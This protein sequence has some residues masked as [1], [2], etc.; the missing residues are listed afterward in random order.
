MKLTPFFVLS[1]LALLV[2]CNRQNTLRE[3]NIPTNASLSVNSV[4]DTV[5]EL[6]NNIMSVYQDKK[7]NYWFGSWQ[8]GLYKYD[9]KTILHFTT[10]NGLPHNRVEDIQED[11]RGNLYFNT[12]GGVCKLSGQKI[13]IL[14]P[15]ISDEWNLQ[16]GD[17]W[18][19]SLQFT[20]KVYR[21]NGKVLY[22]LQFPTCKLG[23]DW[24][25]KHP[26]YSNP[27]AIYTIYKDKKKNVW[28]GTA[29]LGVCRYNGKSFDWISEE[30]VTEL[31]DQPAMGVRSIIEDKDGC[32]WFNTAYRYCIYGKN[33]TPQ[34][35]FYS[36][37]KS[38]GNLDGRP[39]SDFWEFMSIAS[40]NNDHLWVASYA[41]GVWRYDGKKISYYPVQAGGK[42]I[43]MF[44][45]YKDNKG[46]MWLG[47]HEN[48]AY[49]FNG[50]SFER[51]R[52]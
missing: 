36:R 2:S 22:S 39:D 51:F 33:D 45:I 6:G 1:S 24:V 28:F 29:A 15:V 21:Y 47:T 25:K 27:Y 10:K 41:D 34:Q 11:E 3:A 50:K 5:K 8:D 44:Y 52:P 37:E 48:G 18:F 32:F 23:E 46:D 14:Q 16:P 38:I 49:K 40:D 7:N 19:K 12:S 9:G 26:A 30:D 20:G 17:L 13:S 43:T 31:H 35:T 4:A 42:D